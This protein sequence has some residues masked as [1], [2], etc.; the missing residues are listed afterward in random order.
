MFPLIVVHHSLTHP[1]TECYMLHAIWTER[2]LIIHTKLCVLNQYHTNER[3]ISWLIETSNQ[4][5]SFKA[6]L[7]R[8]MCQYILYEPP[9]LPD[10]RWLFQIFQL[11]IDFHFQIHKIRPINSIHFSFRQIL[12]KGWQW[13]LVVLMDIDSA[14]EILYSISHVMFQL[15][16]THTLTVSTRLV[17]VK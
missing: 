2:D 16:S 14:V 15:K 6:D 13:S 12:K 3:S 10:S 11:E 7:S 5:I 8:E 4:H 17:A 9:F 1:C